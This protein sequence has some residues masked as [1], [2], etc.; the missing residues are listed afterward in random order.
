MKSSTDIAVIGMACRFPGAADLESYW[1]NL[2]RGLESIRF[3]TTEEL[4][5]AGE[6]PERLAQAAYV[7]AA[8]V[9]S[10]IDRFDAAFFGMSPRDAAIMDPQHRLFLECAWHA[11]EHAGYDPHRYPGAVGVYAGSGMNSYMMHHLTRHPDLMASVGEWLIRHTGN[12][13]DFLATRAS[14]EFDLKGPSL[15]IQTACSS[16]LVAIHLA[17]QGILGGECDMAL[18]GGV[19]VILPHHRGYVHAPGE[20]LSADG[21]CRAFDAE[22]TGTVFGSGVGIVVLKP[23][24]E[25]VADRDTIYAVIKG[26]AI[27]NDGSRKAGYMAPSVD[28]QAD[29]IS[30]A[31]EVAGVNPESVTYVEAHGTGTV[32]GDPIEI[33]ALTQA[34]RRWTPSKQFCAIGSVKTNIGHLGEAAGVAGFIKSVQAL[35]RGE[36]PPSLH[37]NESNPQIDFAD[38]PFFVNTSLREWKTET[39]PRRAGLTALGVGGTNAH[40][41]LEEAPAAAPSG[42]SRSRHL[43][44]LSARSQTALET[45]AQNLAEHLKAHPDLNLADVA[46][47]LAVGRKAFEHRWMLVVSFPADFLASEQVEKRFDNVGQASSLPVDESSLSRG[48]GSKRPPEASGREP[49]PNSPA[50]FE[51]R[52]TGPITGVADEKKPSVVFMFPGQGSQFINMGRALYL[53]ERVFREEVDRAAR[54]LEPRLHCDLR[55]ILYPA[56]GSE[57]DARKKLDQTAV[58]QPA[59]FVVEYALARM[60]MNWGIQPRALIGHSIGEYVAACLAGVLSF[61]DALALVAARGRLM[62]QLPPGAMLAVPLPELAVRDLLATLAANSA[63]THLCLAAVNARASCVVAGPADE[64]A[65]LEDSLSASKVACRRLKTSHAF[66]SS[67]TE[68][69]LRDYADEVA[70]VSLHA[71]ELPVISNLTGDWLTAVEAVDPAYWVQH[72]RQTVR[73]LDGLQILVRGEKRVF[74]EV[75]PG[76]TLSSFVRQAGQSGFGA[77]TLQSLGQSAE[78]RPRTAARRDG[79][80]TRRGETPLEPWHGFA[81]RSQGS[82]GVSPHTAPDDDLGQALTALGHLWIKGAPVDWQIFYGGEQRRRVPLPAYPFERQ[83][84]WIDPPKAGSETSHA[85]RL[86]GKKPDIADWFYLPSWRK[87]LPPTSENRSSLEAAADVSAVGTARC[88]VCAASSGATKESSDAASTGPVPPA[89]TRAGTSQRDVPTTLDTHEATTQGRFSPSSWCVFVDEFGFGA[90]L[91]ARLARPREPATERAVQLELSRPGDI[92]NLVIRPLERREPG[93]DEVEIQVHAAGLNF[94][95][96]LITL[97]LPH[98]SG[99]RNGTPTLG[100]E[101]AGTI[102]RVGQN[103]TGLR[104]GDG[105]VAAGTGSFQSFVTRPASLVLPKPPALSFEE[106]ATIPGAFVTAYYAL[107]HVAGLGEGERVLIHAASGGVGLAAIQIARQLGAEIYA[108]VGS[109]EKTSFLRRLGLEHI[110]NS[111]SLDFAD[112]IMRQTSGHGVDVVLNSLTGESISRS[113]GILRLGGRFLELGKREILA[114]SG[115]ALTPLNDGRLYAAIDLDEVCRTR[116]AFYRLLLQKVLR[117]MEEGALQ[118]LPARVFAIAEAP[119]AFRLMAQAKH[120][121]KVVLCFQPKHDTVVT[122]SSGAQFRRISSTRFEINPA[123]PEDYHSLVR[124]LFSAGRAPDRVVHLWT[125]TKPGHP[126]LL[127][128]NSSS[129]R[130]RG[131]EAL[132][133]ESQISNPKPQIPERRLTSAAAIEQTASQAALDGLDR[134]LDRGL[135]SLIYFSQAWGKEAH[136]YPLEIDA[137]SN[138]LCGVAGEMILDPAKATLFGASNVIPR[139]FPGVTCRCIDVQLENLLDNTGQAS[140]LPPDRLSARRSPTWFD[141]DRRETPLDQL[142]NELRCGA[143]EAR[144]AYRGR[145]RWVRTFE[146]VK[147]NHRPDPKDHLRPGGVY[148]IT[149]GLGGIGLALAE[150]LAKA[151]SAR[152]ILTGRSQ[153]P[154]ANEWEGWL[155]SHSED[156][157]VSRKIRKLRALQET[158]AEV[159]AATADVGDPIQMEPLIAQALARFGAIHG[160]IHAAGVNDDR[161][162]QLKSKAAV[163]AVLRPK[164]RGTLV[165]EA[166]VPKENLDFF[167]LFSSVSSLVGLAGQADYSAANAFLDAYAQQ[168]NSAGGVWTASIN[169]GPW[170]EVGMAFEAA[171]GRVL[172]APHPKPESEIRFLAPLPVPLLPLQGSEGEPSV[173]AGIT[174]RERFDQAEDRDLPAHEPPLSR[175]TDTLSPPR[176]EGQGEGEKNGSRASR[177]DHAK[178]AERTAAPEHFDSKNGH[179]LLRRILVSANGSVVYSVELH[180]DRDWMLNEHRLRTGQAILPGTAYLELVRAA[181]ADFTGTQRLELRN[182]CF[183]APFVASPDEG[184]ELRVEIA[185]HADEATFRVRSHPCCEGGH[186]VDGQLHAQGDIRPLAPDASIPVH[187]ATMVRNCPQVH[188]TPLRALVERHFNLGARWDNVREVR[189]TQ[190]EI[191]VSLELSGDFAE[192][193]RHYALHPA[194]LDA[195]TGHGQLLIPEFAQH[196]ALYVPFAYQTLRVHSALSAK[197][198]SHIRRTRKAGRNGELATFDV[199]LFD[200]E[201]RRLVD[202][203]GFAMRKVAATTALLAN[204]S[205]RNASPPPNS[206]ES[207]FGNESVFETRT[208]FIRSW[209]KEGMSTAEGLEAFHRILSAQAGPQIVVIPHDLNRIVAEAK[210]CKETAAPATANPISSSATPQFARPNLSALYEAPRDAVEQRVAE[211]WRNLLGLEQVGIQDDFFE[212]GGHSLLAAQMNFRIGDTFAV[213]LPLSALF[214]APTIAQLAER[215][216]QLKGESAP[217]RPLPVIKPAPEDRSLPFPLTDIQ[218]A[219]WAGRGDTHQLGNVSCHSYSEVEMTD[220]NPARLEHALQRLIER[221]DMLR[222]IV[223]QDGQQHIL[224]EVPPYRLEVLDVRG[225]DTQQT[226]EQLAAIRN[227]MSHQVHPSDRWPVFEFRLSRLDDRVSRL[228]ISID[229]LIADAWS[230]EILFRELAQLY[231][232]PQSELAPLELSFRDYVLAARGI[233][234]TEAFRRSRDYWLERLPQLPPAP[235]LPQKQNPAAV[236]RP[237][238]VRRERRLDAALWR[239]LKTRA[240]KADLTASGILLAAYSE[241]LAVWSKSPRFTI[242]LTLFNRLP[243]HPQ[244]NRLIGDF[245]SVTLLEVNRGPAETFEQHAR[246]LQQQ[247]WRDMDHRDFS[248]IQ[249]LRE[250]AR[251]QKRSASLPIVF[252]SLLNMNDA[253]DQVR[254]TNRL[255]KTIYSIS[256][257]PQVYLDFQVYEDGGELVINWDAVE[258]LFPDGLLDEMLPAYENLLRGLAKTSVPAS[259]GLVD[260]CGVL[261]HPGPLPLGEGG[262]DTECGQTGRARLFDRLR[263]I[264]PLPAGEGRGE[265]EGTAVS[266]AASPSAEPASDYWQSDGSEIARSLVPRRQLEQRAAVNATQGPVPDGLLHSGFVAQALRQPSHAAVVTP[267]GR[268]SYDELH[269]R[270][271]AISEQL[272]ALGAEP[273]SLVAV[274]MEKGWEQVAAVLGTLYSGAAYLPIE[275]ELPEERI[276]YLLE[277]GQ[278]RIALT[279]SWVDKRLHWPSNLHRLAVDAIQPD[280]A[281]EPQVCSRR[282]DEADTSKSEIRKP[283]AEMEDRLLTSA[284]T[285]RFMESEAKPDD[286]AYVIYTSGST[287]VPKGVMISHRG[288]LNTILDLHQRFSLSSSDRVLALSALGFDLSVFDVFG[289]LAAGGTIV[290]PDAALSRD[291]A[292]WASLLVKEKVTVWNSVPALMGLLLEQAEGFPEAVGDSLRLILLS[293]DWIPIMMPGQIGELVPGAT[294]LSLGGATEASIWSIL[295]PIEQVDPAWKSIPY[296]KPMRNQTF[297]V[298]NEALEPCPVWVTGELYI[299]GIGLARGYWRDEEKT[300]ERFIVHPRTGERLYRTGDLGR[301]WPDGNIEFLGR[302]DF[303]TKIHGN[304]VELAEIEAELVK[305]SSVAAAAVVAHGDLRGPKRLVA[306]VVPKQPGDTAASWEE[307]SRPDSLECSDEDMVVQPVGIETLDRSRRR[308]EADDTFGSGVSDFGLAE[309]HLVTSAATNPRLMS[310]LSEVGAKYFRELPDSLDFVAANLERLE[311]LSSA[312]MVRALRELG[313]MDGPGLSPSVDTLLERFQI[314]PR[315]RKLVRQWLNVLENDGLI[316]RNGALFH[317]WTFLPESAETARLLQ[318]ARRHQTDWDEPLLDYLERSGE[319]LVRLLTGRVDPL[320]LLF[321]DGSWEAAEAFYEHNSLANCFNHLLREL[322]EEAVRVW[323]QDQPLRIL[324]IGAGTGSTTAALLPILSPERAS[325]CSTDLS[326]FFL[327]GAQKKFASYPFV[328][329]RPL[330]IEENP[331][332]QGFKEH[333]YDIV[334]AANVLHGTRRLAEAL[335]HVRSLLAPGGLLLLFEATRNLRFHLATVGFIEGF[336]R[337]D[338]HR[339]GRNGPLLPAGEWVEFLAAAGFQSASAFPEPGLPAN[340][341]GHHILV[342]STPTCVVERCVPPHPGPLPRGESETSS[343]PPTAARARLDQAQEESLPRPAGEG[344]GEGERIAVPRGISP[345]FG[346]IGPAAKLTAIDECELRASLRS[347][348]PEYMVPSA[349]IQMAALPLSANGKVDR[350]Q[351]PAPEA[352]LRLDDTK[353]VEARDAVEKTLAKVWAE[354]LNLERVGIHDNFFDLGGDSILNIQIVSKAIRAGLRLEPRQLFQ[355]Q[356]I[357]EL[358]R[359]ARPHLSAE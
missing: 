187:L 66:H 272:R 255:G 4:K 114:E 27:N 178:S 144:V 35:H 131:D 36:L 152:L 345:T 296:G 76:R 57:R 177:G 257:T 70:K 58:T 68:P 15:N 236:A 105:V 290:L 242:N 17:C 3:F 248:G 309:V 226:S 148:L 21:H 83:R 183:P 56:T 201:G 293:G 126:T 106:A 98:E 9:L 45:A 237:R 299:G 317:K 253:D 359:A 154:A 278:C 80:Q 282:G 31:L 281:A 158:G 94:K 176:G 2:R 28:R 153:F 225:L 279:Q 222:S 315:N 198:Y 54:L 356:T 135:F 263:T 160:V 300:R 261:P 92:S 184:R 312:Y 203:E 107:C 97:G 53:E 146:P 61:T 297:H 254:W 88:A 250:W 241:L 113:L 74:L 64:I 234:S 227:R 73:F 30:E 18:A 316:E 182:V 155:A 215:I 72:T 125:L 243:L 265:G 302:E 156:D 321:P 75:G 13:K 269:R 319:N 188:Q 210:A 328:D 40:V 294:I 81:Q 200:E 304:R 62:Q 51:E 292:H 108:T 22:A 329:Y 260:R 249:V 310:R 352:V 322:V 256:Q 291:P 112:E 301:Y 19:N 179:P 140:S 341:L 307:D 273:N 168:R 240:G 128:E 141:P 25:A 306:Y 122:V 244:V 118:P 95:D 189:T 138:H 324:E 287:G 145:D 313:A 289:T 208:E 192:D 161:I 85:R 223:L 342:A 318:E 137:V 180:P 349:F 276:R 332:A 37:F 7:P 339:K 44:V 26:S 20:I 350:R 259:N 147:I 46:Y 231:Q 174:G 60:W 336:S 206:S 5:A 149:G 327:S 16:S 175:P 104:V 52:L 271:Q 207:R 357:A 239:R 47:T 77:L 172:S 89:V 233:E 55:E 121:G 335:A 41:I 185:R 134:A 102:T 197:C 164:L 142:V 280:A 266:T 219:Y 314:H 14:Y 10:D 190:D 82:T 353:F 308:V 50:C 212:M 245:T 202:I 199:T 65:V 24:P 264:P 193:L 109:P 229:L 303:Q 347:K 59:L 358:A 204:R 129:C 120:I 110:F 169:W 23:L 38:T 48:S 283:K 8:G 93:A 32:V 116:P 29:V 333:D 295:F 247:L 143:T 87:S 334:V 69:I 170:S 67:M 151:V 165:L 133:Q 181:M 205:P 220:A 159:L 196:Q 326:V 275:A 111:R 86:E 115:G 232:Q 337:F 100:I 238:F 320:Q 246:R 209:L 162:I 218:E 298:L 216:R 323:P 139:E 43:L 288:A 127:T 228:H 258:E 221:H 123:Q 262:I 338:D 274:V 344:R 150:D 355:F 285:S 166:L 124:D 252:T 191:W 91:A 167:I 251:N 173:V 277:H 132:A 63:G 348:L 354:V 217:A 11:L 235:E 194:L 230:F 103:V 33:A 101:C 286:L 78:G 268:I 96:V 195:A 351:L 90:R 79:I 331:A 119:E 340:V 157:P 12:D 343:V 6:N 130:R 1:T 163:E 84:Y 211:I 330:N 171:H 305:H 136:D 39:G 284:A 346:D 267:H 270:A 42:P 99:A 34:F 311:R 325:Y 71:P 214:E 117:Q 224:N 49:A 213:E 186:G